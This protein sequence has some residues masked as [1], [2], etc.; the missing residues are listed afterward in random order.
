MEK[1]WWI[2]NRN[3]YSGYLTIKAYKKALQKIPLVRN[4]KN[5]GMNFR[6]F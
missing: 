1:G 6:G 5:P 3:Q 4:A 2:V